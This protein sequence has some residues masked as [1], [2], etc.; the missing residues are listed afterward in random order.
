MEMAEAAV[1]TRWL[2][3]GGPQTIAEIASEIGVS[4]STLRRHSDQHA[5]APRGCKVE[6]VERARSGMT[7]AGYCFVINQPAR[8]DLK[9][10]PA[11]DKITTTRKNTKDSATY[12][13]LKNGVVSPLTIHRNDNELEPGGSKLAWCVRDA[14]VWIDEAEFATKREAVAFCA[15]YLA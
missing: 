2:A 13:V 1:F 9:G 8:L 11:M 5:G 15:G 10:T 4:E 3:G 7:G 14:G 6:H 12:K